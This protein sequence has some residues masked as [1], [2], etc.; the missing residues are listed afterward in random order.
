MFIDDLL[1]DSLIDC[2]ID[3]FVDFFIYQSGYQR[4]LSYK[5][6]DGSYSAFGDRDKEGSMW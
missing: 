1:I 6:P 5:H 4:E 3:W 2:L